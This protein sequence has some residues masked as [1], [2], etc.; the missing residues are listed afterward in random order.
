M[1]QQIIPFVFF[2]LLNSFWS[3]LV[4]RKFGICLPFT[5]MLSVFVLYWSQFLFST[6][7]VGYVALWG[8]AVAAPIIYIVS[9]GKYRGNICSF[10]MYSYIAACMI[11]FVIDFGK[12]LL[13]WDEL[14]HW[15]MMTKEMCRLDSFYTDGLSRL[16]VH[17]EYPPFVSL[18]EVLWCKLSGGFS[19]MGS[20]I[21]VH[22]MSSCLLTP[23]LLEDSE[24]ADQWFTKLGKA[25]LLN[26][27]YVLFILAFDKYGVYLTIYK[28]FIFA[29][30]FVYAMCLIAFKD[31]FDDVFSF[32]CFVMV[33]SALLLTKQM[34]IAFVLLIFLYVCLKGVSIKYVCL[35]CRDILKWGCGLL[36]VAVNYGAWSFHTR[37]LASAGQFSLSNIS[38]ESFLH[39]IIGKGSEVQR[40][41]FKLY[42]KALFQKP[43]YD[44]LFEMS[45]ISILLFV[46]LILGGIWYFN[47]KEFS[48]RDAMNLGSVFVI[49]T[50]G[51]MFTM[52]VLY[53]FTFSEGEML[54]LASYSRYM[55]S[56]VIG[57]LLVLLNLGL[58]LRNKKEKIR[59]FN[60]FVLLLV[61]GMI[62]Y[63]GKMYDL[64]PQVLKTNYADEYREHAF[65]LEKQLEDNSK[66]FVV[67]ERKNQMQTFVSFY[68]EDL[69]VA[70]S[71]TDVLNVGDTV[72]REAVLEELSRNEYI[73]LIDISERFETEFGDMINVDEVFE[74]GAIYQID[75]REKRWKKIY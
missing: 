15:G 5:L 22:V 53:L 7:D 58:V 52:L 46:L 20:T 17:R 8:M 66:V 36:F 68:T 65:V 44:H 38:V 25:L 37:E 54:E 2:F 21:A 6:F 57:E 26:I 69:R 73:Y 23:Y 64:I 32:I 28:D 13:V 51:W 75:C 62:I 59:L 47:K 1:I 12:E 27:A 74:K 71:Q 11:F 14:S 18:F 72:S 4:K 16:G 31:I 29:F 49:G 63:P 35:K 41:T 45:Y 56:Y 40:E 70:V 10:G 50:T 33:C 43:L 55:S 34:G 48:T 39:S 67:S 3:I 19:A 42:I 24:D 9:K 60:V 61:A 30:M